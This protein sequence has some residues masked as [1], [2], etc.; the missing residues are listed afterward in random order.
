MRDFLKALF[1]LACS[2][3]QCVIIASIAWG[4]LVVS[5]P[6]LWPE[7]PT[8]LLHPDYLGVVG[9]VIFYRVLKTF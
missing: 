5:A 7:G 9:M 1:E 8:L 6:R 4:L 2:V 3:F